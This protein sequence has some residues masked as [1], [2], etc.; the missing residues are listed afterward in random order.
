MYKT[1]PWDDFLESMVPVYQKHFPKGD[2]DTLMAFYS[3]P[4][5][6]SGS[7]STRFGLQLI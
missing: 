4:T 6:Q 5:G 1:F 7:G 2:V 3:T